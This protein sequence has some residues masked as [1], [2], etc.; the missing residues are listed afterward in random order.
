MTVYLK[1]LRRWH[2][3]WESPSE[4]HSLRDWAF[5]I[6]NEYDD[7]LYNGIHGFRILGLEI[8]QAPN[9]LWKLLPL[10]RFV[11]RRP[12]MF[13]GEDNEG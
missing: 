13:R 2:G 1:F 11:I 5:W 9:W 3:K 8:G 7:W 6:W 4:F 10:C 12:E